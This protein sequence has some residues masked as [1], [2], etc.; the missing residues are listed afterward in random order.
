MIMIFVYFFQEAEEAK[1]FVFYFWLVGM[2]VEQNTNALCFWIS[3]VK[4]A[5]HVLE[6]KL[7]Y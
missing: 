1:P 6:I 3:A 7:A 2:V 4:A 5:S